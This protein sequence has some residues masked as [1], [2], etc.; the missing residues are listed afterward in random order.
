MFDGVEGVAR[1]DGRSVRLKHKKGNDTVLKRK[2]VQ[3]IFEG[4]AL[5]LSDGF[6]FESVM[7]P[8]KDQP[9]VKTLLDERRAIE[10]HDGSAVFTVTSSQLQRGISATVT[11]EDSLCWFKDQH[12][13]GEVNS[14]RVSIHPGPKEGGHRAMAHVWNDAVPDTGNI[15]MMFLVDI[16]LPE[17]EFDRLFRNIWLAKAPCRLRIE[18][19]IVCF[20]EAAEADLNPVGFPNNFVFEADEP[21]PV[22]LN[23]IY[24]EGSTLAPASAP[25]WVPDKQEPDED[26]ALAA[27]RNLQSTMQKIEKALRWLLLFVVGIAVILLLR[28]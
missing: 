14:R 1:P 25:L 28:G 22:S 26:E 9:P 15:N 3:L 12:F 2:L 17:Q 10:E 16:A 13:G 8:A 27:T 6:Y 18:L 23:G 20:Q 7:R 21:I 5:T 24:A 4:R 19:H 11:T